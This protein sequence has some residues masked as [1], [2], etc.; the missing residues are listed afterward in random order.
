VRFALGLTIVCAASLICGLMMLLVGETLR[1]KSAH[2]QGLV[3]AGGVVAICGLAAGLALLVVLTVGPADR[4]GRRPG[5]GRR[6]GTGAARS[7]APGRP[8]APQAGLTPLP[9]QAELAPLPLP[10]AFAAPPPAGFAVPPPAA[11]AAPPPAGFAVPP[12]AGFAVPPAGFPPPSAGLAFPPSAAPSPERAEAAWEA[13]AYTDDGWYPQTR[14]DWDPGPAYEWSQDGRD[15]WEYHQAEYRNRHEHDGWAQGAWGDWAPD[16]HGA[17]DD[18]ARGDWIPAGHGDPGDRDEWFDDRRDDRA[19]PS[20]GDVAPSAGHAGP[21]WA[22]GD[23][24][25]PAGLG[26]QADDLEADDTSPLPVIP[27]AAPPAPPAQRPDG[28]YH[29]VHAEPPSADTQEKIERIKDLYLTA[30]AIGEDALVRHFDQLKTMQRSLIREFFEKAGLG[31]DSDAMNPPGH[32]SEPAD[33]GEPAPADGGES[34]PDGAP[35]P[36]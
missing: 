26:P 31:P 17:G 33:G 28:T 16:G 1:L 10:A 15:D 5:S 6:A 11:F 29:P 25:A 8:P 23:A 7:P 21:G 14:D 34:A 13:A 9:P 30:E 18:P 2:S 35:L 36:G 4:F 32:P 24:W 3:Q 19:H 12:P 22:A 27:A 20:W